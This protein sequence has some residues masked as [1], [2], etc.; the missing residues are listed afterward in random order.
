MNATSFG[1]KFIFVY[2][3]ASRKGI[4]P[5]VVPRYLPK[6]AHFFCGQILFYPWK[7]HFCRVQLKKVPLISPNIRTACRKFKKKLGVLA[8]AMVGG[9]GGSP[10]GGG[11]DGDRGQEG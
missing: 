6:G 3:L 7:M 9:E 11:G 5:V 10:P 8:I 1:S 4:A 2:F